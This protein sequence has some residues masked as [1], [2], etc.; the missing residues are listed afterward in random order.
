MARKDRPRQVLRAERRISAVIIGE[1]R[2]SVRHVVVA[3]I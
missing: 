1:Q 3:S 2:V